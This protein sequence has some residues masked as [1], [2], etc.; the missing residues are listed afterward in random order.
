VDERELNKLSYL[1]IALRSNP[2][3]YK[4]IISLAYDPH[5]RPLSFEAKRLLT[6]TSFSFGVAIKTDPKSS[7][8]ALCHLVANKLLEWD[9]SNIT[10]MFAEWLAFE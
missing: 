6:Y 4:E 8:K 9:N 5:L 10:K 1:A 7:R 2:H 3:R